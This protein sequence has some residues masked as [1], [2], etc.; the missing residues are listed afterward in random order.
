[1]NMRLRKD[2]QVSASRV[3]VYPNMGDGGLCT[4]AAALACRE[5]GLLVSCPKGNCF[6]G[7]SFEED[8]INLA[9][10]SRSIGAALSQIEFAQAVA[11]KLHEGEVV[12]IF[13]GAMEFG[14]RALGHR[15]LL[16]QAGPDHQ[17]SCSCSGNRREMKKRGFPLF[18]MFFFF[19]SLLLLL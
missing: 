10:E 4:G 11:A 7:P 17:F 19:P 18:H 1:L 15:S 13:W 16:V 2:L 3:F 12:G 6:L 9:V 8:Q 5:L 14:P